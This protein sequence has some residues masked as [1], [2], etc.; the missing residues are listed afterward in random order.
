MFRSFKSFVWASALPCLFLSPQQSL[1]QSATTLEAVTTIATKTERGVDEVPNSVVVIGAEEIESRAP[2]KLQD[3]LGDIPGVDFAGGPRRTSTVPSIRGLDLNRVV[4]TIDGARQNFDAGHKGRVFLDPDLLKQVEV[5]KGPGSTLNGAGAIGGVIALTTKDAGDFLEAGERAGYK[6]KAGYGSVDRER[7]YS[8]TLFG[9]PVDTVELLADI[10]RRDIGTTKLGGSKELPNSDEDINS[11]LLKGSLKPTQFSKV[12][13]THNRF[14]ETGRAPIDLDTDVTANASVA[15]RRTTRNTT[16]IN[17]A[18]AN[19]DNPWVDVH[20]VAYRNAINVAE[21]RVSDRRVD[22]TDLRTDGFD[23]Y[24]T[25]RF[26]VLDWM[27]HAVTLG[28]EGYHDDQVASRNGANRPAYPL[29]DAKVGG[30]YAQ[31]EISLFDRVTLTPGARFDRYNL[32][33][34][35]VA[36]S[37]V[38]EGRLSPKFGVLWKALPWL[39]VAGSYAEAFRAPSL[40]ELFLTGQHFPG[41]NFV[42]N[43]NLRPETTRTWEGGLR[44]NFKDV[45]QASDTVKFNVTYYR[46]AAEDFIEQVVNATTTIQRNVPSAELNGAEAQLSYDSRLL[47]GSIGYARIRGTNETTGAALGSVPPDRV[48]TKIGVKLPEFDS[49]I[50]A[51]SEFAHEQLRVPTGALVTSGYAVHGLFASWSPSM[52]VLRGLRV[53]LVADNILDNAYRRHLSAINE[54]GRDLRG[55]VSWMQK[56]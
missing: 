37:E 8:T 47:F 30:V 34:P 49:V 21:R 25:S 42:P 50:G 35:S 51:R 54:P 12:T 26:A 11:Y 16:N 32:T 53:D 13:L 45:L 6:L 44:F 19:P 18:Y 56:F 43:P 29:A 38:D 2:S 55:T 4:T 10:G 48:N 23:A 7:Q 39:N 5:L 20:A 27:R 24:N 22:E 1:A 17:L 52:D 15:D 31:D 46:T 14:T 40:T 41:N 33:T 28:A 36:N 3:M 9:R